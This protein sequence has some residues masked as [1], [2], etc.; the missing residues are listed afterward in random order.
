MSDTEYRDRKI[1]NMTSR[2][3]RK[4]H[5]IVSIFILAIFGWVYLHYLAYGMYDAFGGYLELLTNTP[6]ELSKKNISQGFI[7]ILFFMY[8][9]DAALII[10]LILCNLSRIIYLFKRIWD[11]FP[12]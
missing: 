3:P 12:D 5:I 6:A 8:I 9:G 10:S 11:L 1:H 4:K 2:L 7:I